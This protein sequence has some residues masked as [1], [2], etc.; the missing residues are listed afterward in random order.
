M[1]K[2]EW[3]NSLY[4]RRVFALYALVALCAGIV[5]LL[6]VSLIYD[7]LHTAAGVASFIAGVVSA[8]AVKYGLFSK[9]ANMIAETLHKPVGIPFL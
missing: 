9:A 2:H 6:V 3:P 1:A 7:P 4:L 5:T 8:M